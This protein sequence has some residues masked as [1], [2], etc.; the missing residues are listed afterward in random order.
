MM[1]RDLSETVHVCVEGEDLSQAMGDQLPSCLRDGFGHDQ[2]AALRE[3]VRPLHRVVLA[4][5]VYALPLSW[6]PTV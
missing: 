4:G 6:Y 3:A 1:P 2:P 5:L